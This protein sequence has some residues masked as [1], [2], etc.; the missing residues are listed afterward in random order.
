[1]VESS[2]TPSSRI[3]ISLIFVLFVILAAALA[4]AWRANLLAHLLPDGVKARYGLVPDDP[5][6]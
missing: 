4:W 1:M 5:L 3:G 6:K 2:N